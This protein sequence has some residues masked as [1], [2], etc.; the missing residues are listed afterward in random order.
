MSGRNDRGE[1]VSGRNDRGEM[2]IVPVVQE[3][4]MIARRD[5]GEKVSGRNDRGETVSGREDRGE[6]MIARVVQEVPMIDRV[7]R[8]LQVSGRN[9]HAEKVIARRVRGETVIGRVVRVVRVIGRVV[10]EALMIDPYVH[11]TPHNVEQMKFVSEP[12]GESTS[13]E[14]CR[15]S[16]PPKNS[17][18]TKAQYVNRCPVAS[19]MMLRA[20]Q[21]AAQASRPSSHVRLVH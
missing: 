3:A 19:E 7:V 11:K 13:A 18:S 6:M 1:T 20:V 12:V 16:V 17:G 8:V 9:G 2:M 4:L 15:T 10:Q 5:R 21:R 14:K